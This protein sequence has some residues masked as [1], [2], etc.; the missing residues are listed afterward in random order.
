MRATLI[1]PIWSQPLRTADLAPRRTAFSL[2]PDSAVRAAIA[3]E[4]G[5][6]GLRKMRFG[7]EITPFGSSGWKL[8]ARLGA[9]VVQACVLTL[10]PVTTRIDEK[11]YRQYSAKPEAQPTDGEIEMPGDET[12]ELLGEFIDPGLV[13]VEATAVQPEGRITAWDLGLWSEDQAESLK[14]IVEVI[15][16]QGST[17]AIQLAHARRKASHQRPWHGGGYLEPGR[18]GWEIS[19]PS[20]I[21]YEETWGTPQALSLEEI[22]G[23]VAGFASAARRSVDVGMRVIEL[24]LAHGYLGCEFLSPLSN[25][26]HDEYGGPLENRAFSTTYSP[27]GEES[28][29]RFHAPVG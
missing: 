16:S 18:G 9:T 21:K 29:A 20:P 7:G 1:A 8:S 26:R 3:K 11:I 24:H 22:D 5:L 10:D 19:G 17:P 28:H 2:T 13:M 25:D 12:P 4:L 23:V 27:G 14:P 15:D 6:L